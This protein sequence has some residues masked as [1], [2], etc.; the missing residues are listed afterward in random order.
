MIFVVG[1]DYKHLFLFTFKIE[2]LLIN[3]TNNITHK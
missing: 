1:G 3:I 2:I